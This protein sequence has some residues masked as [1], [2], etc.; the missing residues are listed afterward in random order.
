MHKTRRRKMTVDTDEGKK[1]EEQPGFLT[2][3]Q[4]F[5]EAD[6]ALSLI[7]KEGK[8]AGEV[9]GRI[10]ALIKKVP[11]QKDAIEINDAIL[12]VIALTRTEAENN[13]VS[14]RTQFAEAL[15]PVNGDRVQLQRVMLNLVVNA[16]Q[17]MKGIGD[18][19]RELQIRIDAVPSEG[20]VRVGV[21]D[22]GPGLSPESLSRHGHGHG[23]LDL[24]LDHRS[25][26]WAA[27]GDRV[28]AA[29]CSLS[30]YNPR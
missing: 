12:E 24:P 27:V 18:G 23:P 21:R 16:I 13:S 3:L 22:T 20:G 30:V 29:G 15:P 8:R 6:D 4:Y 19:T 9:I 28:R 14:V 11:A 7:V 26:W 17:A 25:P 5:H 10:R 1:P 2:Q